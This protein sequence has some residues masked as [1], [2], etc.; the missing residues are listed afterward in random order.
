MTAWTNERIDELKILWAEGLS[1]TEIADKFGG[2]MTRNAVIGKVHRLG[3]A[4]RNDRKKGPPVGSHQR[5]HRRR[6]TR[7][8]M[9]VRRLKTGTHQAPRIEVDTF[10]IYSHPD[11]DLIPF[12]QRCTLL[13]LTPFNC[14][15]PVGDPK[16]DNF[17]FCG[18]ATE[19]GPYCAYHHRVG[20]QPISLER[21]P[22]VSQRGRKA[23]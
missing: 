19:T 11:D 7:E 23:A 9:Q 1:G 21:H 12:G 4:G 20:Y 16:S 14:H 5:Y 3:L 2:V 10:Q 13:E 8:E 18:G 17:F 15:W 22:F 6:A